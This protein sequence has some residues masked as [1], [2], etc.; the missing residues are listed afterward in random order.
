MSNNWISVKDQLPDTDNEN[1]SSENVLAILDGQVE[2]MCYCLVPDDN[3]ELCYA[4]CMVYD[5]LRGDGEFDGNYF[6]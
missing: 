2:I 1:Q 6:L 3:N 5:G 4:W